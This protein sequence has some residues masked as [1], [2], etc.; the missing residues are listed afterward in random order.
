MVWDGR[1]YRSK[2]MAGMDGVTWVA[3]HLIV[4]EAGSGL[5]AW[6]RTCSQQQEDKPPYSGI[7]RASPSILLAAVPLAAASPVAEP[8]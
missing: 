8:V 1:P 3:P 4:Q 7:S 2:D 6:K 5:L